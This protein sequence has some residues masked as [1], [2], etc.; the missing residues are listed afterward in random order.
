M[1]SGGIQGNDGKIATYRALA[2][3]SRDAPGIIAASQLPEADQN[4]IREFRMLTESLGLS[5]H[6]A[7]GRIEW[8]RS[9]E[10]RQAHEA[11][12]NQFSGPR[13]TNELNALTW[14]DIA[15]HFN[16]EWFSTPRAAND[17]VQALA[18]EAYRDS[19]RYW[20]ERGYGQDEA[21]GL[22]LKDLKDSG[23]WGIS[24]LMGH[25][26]QALTMYPIEGVLGEGRKIDGS[27]DWVERQLRGQLAAYLRT[28]PD[29][30]QAANSGRTD[31]PVGNYFLERSQ[32][33]LSPE[34]M[35]ELAEFRLVPTR[36]TDADVTSGQRDSPRYRMF[37]RRADGTLDD[38]GL[39]ILDYQG[40]RRLAEWHAVYPRQAAMG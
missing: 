17:A 38:A 23:R 34:R 1:S 39:V 40:A 29:I 25:G 15:S 14:N 9:P 8:R 12:R 7:I 10:G 31:R 16:R 18:V 11:M 27:F 24:H 35:A 37:F 6:E 36:E 33:K 28:R 32:G 5:E 13:R 3:I 30:V 19:Y 26:T 20:R 21:R 2:N 4:R 22:A